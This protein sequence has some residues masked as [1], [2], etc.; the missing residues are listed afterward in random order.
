M[1]S[2]GFRTRPT[3]RPFFLFLNY[4]DAHAPFIPPRTRPAA[5]RPLRV[6][7]TSQ[8]E[9]MEPSQGAEVAGKDAG[10]PGRSRPIV[11]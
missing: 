9:I 1:H 3:D 8:V 4:Y 5:V 2:G 10:D 7:P 11:R 6:P